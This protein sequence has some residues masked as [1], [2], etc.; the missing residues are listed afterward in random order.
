MTGGCTPPVCRRS[1]G[2]DDTLSGL[3]DRHPL[4][5]GTVAGGDR[6][7]YSTLP[8]DHHCE[9]GKVH[10]TVDV[11]WKW[12]I[13]SGGSP[14]SMWATPLC[15]RCAGC[16][17]PTGAGGE[18]ARPSDIMP[19]SRSASTPRVRAGGGCYVYGWVAS[20]PARARVSEDVM[21]KASRYLSGLGSIH[22]SLAEL[23]QR[24]PTLT[25][26]V[27]LG[28]RPLSGIHQRSAPPHVHGGRTIHR[29]IAPAG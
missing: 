23:T 26:G 8:A 6:G 9:H 3:Q 28:C 15:D 22:I 5:A 4:G 20:P 10:L 11:H 7:A 12:T 18:S 16:G 21:L 29:L 27:S 25:A 13:T 17:C 14:A 2:R 1:N 19:T 24:L